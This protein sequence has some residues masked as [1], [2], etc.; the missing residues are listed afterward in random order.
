MSS[1]ETRPRK[2]E[3]DDEVEPVELLV[4]LAERGEIDPWDIDIVEVTD[5]F[6]AELDARDLRTSGRALFYAS[7]LL[8]MKSDD[9]LDPTDPTD[10]V[11]QGVEEPWM[12]PAAHEDGIDPID[13]LEREIERRIERKHARGSPETLDEL[14]RELREAEQGSWWKES[15]EYDTSESPSGFQRGTQTLDYHARDDFRAEHEPTEADV[16]GTAHGEEMEETI[17]AIRAELERQYDAGR[18][19]VLFEEIDHIA[20]SRVEAFLATLFL[21]HRGHVVL[22]QAVLFGDLW[23]QDPTAIPAA[24]ELPGIAD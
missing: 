24:E 10:E 14:V 6:L 5:A 11:G 19:E 22:D 12:D 4:G 20:E 21:A 1:V 8:R 13:G 7:V 3:G 9:L 2:G 16:T 17:E 23:I 15:R 18:T